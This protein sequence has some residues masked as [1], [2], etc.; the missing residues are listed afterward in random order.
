[1]AALTHSP[2]VAQPLTTEG[3]IVGTFQ[4][5]APE[6]LEGREADARGDIWALGCV[7]YE[8]ATGRRAFE[9]RSQASL[10]AA[11]LE[12]QPPPLSESA[13]GTPVS[14][15]PSSNSMSGGLPH[16]LDRLIRN[17]LA[18]DPDDRVQTAHDVKL[19]L[20]GIAEGAGISGASVIA[21]QAPA[22]A[23]R[24]APGIR[25]AWAVAAIAL[26]AAAAAVA[27]LYP[28]ASAPAASYRFRLSP[29][30]GATD[31]FWPRVS[32]DGTHILTQGP[33]SSGVTRAY[34]RAMNEIT[35]LSIA[36]TEGLRRAYWSPDSREIAFVV[37][38]KIMRVPVS[39]GTPVIVA[40]AASG[41][42]LSWGS[43]GIIL[44]DGQFTDS[45]KVVPAGGGELKPATRI[46][47]TRHEVGTGWPCFL[48]DGEHFLF[49][50]NLEGAGVST[51]DIRLGRVGS[52]DSKWLG[53]SD[54]RVEYAPG[55]WVLFVRGNALLAQKLDVGAG[56]LTGE[57]ITITDRL[58][59]GS[60]AGHFSV[61]R[62]GVLA[63]ALEAGGDAGTFGLRNRTGGEIGAALPSGLMSNP[64]L[65][66]DGRKLLYLNAERSLGG[67]GEVYV[68]DLDRAT[69]TR[70]TFSGNL[71]RDPEW[72]PDG[73]RFAYVTRA[74]S[75]RHDAPR[76][77]GRRARTAGFPGHA[78]WGRAG[79]VSMDGGRLA[80]GGQPGSATPGVRA[81]RRGGARVHA[82]WRLHADLQASAGLSRWTLAGRD[83]G[84]VSE[85]SRFRP[86]PGGAARAL[87][88]L[89]RRRRAVSALDAGRQGT[90]VR[91]GGPPP[92]GGRHRYARKLPCRNAA[93]A[94]H[95]A[96][97]F[98]RVRRHQLG[99]RRQRAR[100]S[101]CSPRRAPRTAA[102]WKW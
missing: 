50:G 80:A 27:W 12:R 43:K 10:I 44:R 26:L 39:G 42:D 95:A 81:Q 94:V 24:T 29:I 55:D 59:V 61:S 66:P 16:G 58:R 100:S 9:G 40:E 34:V 79:A 22:L 69:N 20:Q 6:Q 49:I 75:G 4:Y 90:G 33:D 62:T 52:L 46:D 30:A 15:A 21:A 71:A 102:R 28:R 60:S 63:F 97:R 64:R 23:V 99:L 35:A 57:P 48:P 72:S 83:D 51:G 101:W 87:A 13:P 8:M 19:Q 31:Q 85:R 65:S 38:D 96:G 2:T 45:L 17:C 77:V 3:T 54:G 41:A 37:N 98:V 14:G 68:F 86:E 73:A 93:R 84:L 53:S 82:A 91:G 18:K 89:L 5:M 47:R 67:S 1:M 70:L 76:D 25:L 32:P 7:L 78:G 11:I 56:K 74:R 88:D 36:G 92:H